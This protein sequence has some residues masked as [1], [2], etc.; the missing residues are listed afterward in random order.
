MSRTH[1]AGSPRR[2]LAALLAVLLLS[3]LAGCTTPN[4]AFDPRKPHHRPD[5]FQNLHPSPH[6]TDNVSFWRWQW[7]R[8]RADLPPDRPERVAR[9]APDTALLNSRHGH[10]T[11]TWLGHSTALW[12]VNG[13]NILTDPHLGPRASPV[14]F[15]GPERLTAAP[16]TAAQLPHI[17][18]V[19]ISHNHYDHLD[20]GTV[21]ALARQPGGSPLFVVPLGVERWMADH[22]ITRTQRMDWWDHRTL[23]APAGAVTLHFVP[24]HHWS[25]RTP[26]DRSATL[27]GGF[28]VQAMMD[29]QPVSL[30]FAGDT[31]YAP[32][33]AEIGRRFGG[34][35]LS[36]IPVGCYLPRWFMAAQHVNEEEAVRI[37]RDVKSRLSIGVHWGTFR[38]CDDPIDT[39]IDGL[40][41]A[42][43][44]LQVPA[45][46][47]VLPVLGQ[48]RVLRRAV[49]AGENRPGP[50]QQQ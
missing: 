48:T 47:F 40:P 30:Y 33:F 26:W 6:G 15:A 49:L 17:D 20:E 44:R 18:V 25:S 45:E 10:L 9:E 37:H 32:D 27:W 42:R 11:V 14:S 19:L 34:F 16:L 50:G 5:G 36:M 21:K 38:L 24:S 3:L 31:G 7:E 41:A 13:L 39:P 28:V 22:G 2:H 8:W 29:G 35:D 23:P 46:A 4:T 1:I 12:Q 43:E